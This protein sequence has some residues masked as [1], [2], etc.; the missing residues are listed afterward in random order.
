MF[1]RVAWGKVKPGT[2]EEYEQLYRDEI[3]PNTRG[4]RGLVFRE[5]LRGADDPDEGISLTLWQSRED[6][7]A[8]E[9]SEVYNRIVDRARAYYAGE[10][11]VKHFDVRL[12]EQLGPSAS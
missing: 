1:A 12:G 2:W 9:Q 10:Y 6:L 8:Y 4:V 11:W 3:L 7:D 5:L